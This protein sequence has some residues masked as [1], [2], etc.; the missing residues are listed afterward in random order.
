MPSVV[1]ASLSPFI[2]QRPL[3][4]LGVT[5]GLMAWGILVSAAELLIWLQMINL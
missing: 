2:R 3:D 5:V 1:E 4:K